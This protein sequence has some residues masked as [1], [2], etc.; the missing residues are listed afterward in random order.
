MLERVPVG[1]ILDFA[2]AEA[3]ARSFGAAIAALK[4]DY[5]ACGQQAQKGVSRYAWPSVAREIQAI[6]DNVLGTKERTIFGVPVRVT[7]RE[8]AVARLDAEAADHPVSVAFLNAH[9]ANIARRNG[10]FSQCLQNSVVLNDGIGVDLA[11]LWLYGRRF[12]ENLN[13]TDFTIDYL[14]RTR[15]S[16]S[17]YL[18]G[19]RRR[20]VTQA[21]IRLGA[22]LS[23]HRIVGYHDGYFRPEDGAD[24]VADIRRSGA[25]LLLV[26]LG[27]PAQELWIAEH[28]EEIGCRVA[29]AVG[30]LFDFISGSTPRAPQWVRQCRGEWLYRLLLE[31]RR[32]AGRYLLGNFWFL[33]GL[34]L[35]QGGRLRDR[36]AGM[37]ERT[38]LSR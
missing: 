21:A 8:D 33:L 14:A 23:R 36:A 4:E 22:K 27:N 5:A 35:G 9:G 16:Y 28:M 37:P 38:A 32:L 20:V 29:F 3:A 26:G 34:W 11:S 2:D 7:T 1:A 31:P 25:D 17:I 6:Y 10:A 12:P 18:F 15:R 13:G 24:I 19:A 30:A